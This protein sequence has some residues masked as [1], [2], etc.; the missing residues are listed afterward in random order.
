MEQVLERLPADRFVRVHRS[1]IVNLDRIRQ[2]H[3]W[4]N[5]YLLVLVDGTRLATGRQYRD[6]VMQ[7]LHALR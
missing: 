4:F 2:V 6:T 5:G 7:R 1:T 3:D